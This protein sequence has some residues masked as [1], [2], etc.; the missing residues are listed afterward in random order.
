V[1]P[2]LP[3][4]GGTLLPGRY[5]ADDVEGVVLHRL[6]PDRRRVREWWRRVEAHCGPA[7]GLRMLFDVAAMP[8]FALLGFRARA[9]VFGAD[10]V[11]VRLETRAGTAVALVVLPWAH[12]PTTRWRA[13][14]GAARDAGARWAFALAPPFLSIVDVRGHATRRSIDFTLP[15]ALDD[16]SVDRFLVLAGAAAF[17]AQGRAAGSL[18]RLVAQAL[19]WQDRVRADLQRGVVEALGALGPVLGVRPGPVAARALAARAEPTVTAP[20]DE[21]LTLIYRMLFLLFAESRDLVPRRHPVYGPAYSVT[22]LC[23]EAV[24]APR[25]RGLWEG[26]AAITRLS[27]A[28]CRVDDLIVRPFNGRLFAR[29]SAPALE[30]GRRAR[31]AA[32]AAADR[33]AALARALTALGTRRGRAGREE[34][35]YA[36]LGVEQLGA[37]YERVLDLDPEEIAAGAGT[38]AGTVTAAGAGAGAADAPRAVSAPARHSAQRKQTGTFYTPQPL[39]EFLVRRTLAPLVR[40]ASADEILA[41]RVVDPAMG[42]GAFLV[43]A[44]R[45]LAAAYERALVDDGRCAETDLDD[46]A[47]A[48]H[49]RLIAERCLAGVDLNPVAV[50]LARLS[51]WLTTLAHGKPL[52][53][54]DH[55]LR[56]GNS[57]VGASPGDLWRLP[58]AGSGRAG[59]AAGNRPLFDDDPGLEESLRRTAGPLLEL[60][61]R[62]DDTVADVRAKEATWARL[63]G[64]HSPL[65]AWRLAC[66]LWCA[67]FFWARGRGHA[68]GPPPSAPELRA[69]IDAIVRGDRTIGASHLDGWIRVA[70]DAARRH[71]FFHWPLEFVDVF[72]DARGVPRARPGFDAVIGNPPWEM[73]R[74]D[75]S[76]TVHGLPRDERADRGARAGPPST[77]PGPP[78]DGA[79]DG[80]RPDGARSN[81][82]RPGGARSDGGRSD[83]ARP[84]GARSDGPPSDGARFDGRRAL[85]EFVRGSGLY[86][87]CGRG[88]LNLYQPFVERALSIVRPG[89]R[90]G[91]ILPWGVATDDG[92]AELRRRLLDRCGHLTWLGLDNA[93]A[94]F[95]IHRGLRFA[96][97]AATRDGPAGAVRGRFG[98][99]TSDEIEA[100]PDFDDPLGPP[101]A[102][103]FDVR[104]DAD[105]LRAIGGPARRIPDLRRRADLDW[106]GRICRE[107]P[108]LGDATGWRARFGRELNATDDRDRFGGHGLPVIDG[109][110]IGPF[111]VDARAA[112]RFITRAAARQQLPACRFEGARLGYRDVSGAGNRLSLIAAIVPADVVT[113]HTIF[114]LRTPLPPVQQQ[115]LCGL[116][117]AYVLNA[118]VRMFMGAHVTTS[119]VEGLPVPAWTGSPAQRRIARLA[120]RLARRPH[121]PR[122]HAAL[123]ASVA[124]LYGIEAETF[125]AILESFPLVPRGD[126]DAAVAALRG[127]QGGASRADRVPI[128]TP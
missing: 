73:L 36:D 83:G 11:Q 27:R 50:Q 103:A 15:D 90:I 100:L 101:A 68:D 46:A 18:D 57:L 118:V 85:L 38:G 4:I 12:R 22:A 72:F 7:S 49:R 26:L 43:A 69:A 8:L 94:L 2:L 77:V 60:I 125:A 122:L 54:L 37:V 30:R 64:V 79:F 89:G 70:R 33:D 114:C 24:S 82:A 97:I 120:A 128:R 52:S 87:S 80:A 13:L 126:R 93:G 40:G 3:G 21:S 6:P 86:P 14:T 119:L 66:S 127:T 61:Q 81:R 92:A 76:S 115:F 121:A 45:Y 31:P 1:T 20:F 124:R 74:S 23:R 112:G 9:A 51:L 59:A 96:A 53:F 19:T 62:P 88:H 116:F 10:A 71:G 106:L 102:A 111:V 39:A 29:A 109:K 42:S 78:S 41:L 48:R 28:G 58:V 104:L 63:A 110:H 105:T 17:D 47:H 44:C 32:G 16:R 91:L 75:P 95:P 67:R 56:A 107:F 35:A 117:N 123:Q 25:A 55:R 34:I 5:L 84:E 99:R 98:V 65:D 113:T 108:A